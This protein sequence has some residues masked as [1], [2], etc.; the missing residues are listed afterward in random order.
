MKVGGSIAEKD[1]VAVPFGTLAGDFGILPLP[2]KERNHQGLAN[3]VSEA[4]LLKATSGE[5]PAASNMTRKEAKGKR[6]HN[7][8]EDAIKVM[9][10]KTKVKSTEAKEQGDGKEAVLADVLHVDE[11]AFDKADVF[12]FPYME[13]QP[14]KSPKNQL[15]RKWKNNR[16]RGQK[17]QL[18]TK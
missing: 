13:E 18:L 11:F 4:P 16:K 14:E 9:E 10:K 8:V 6:Y 2:A 1:V 7:V 5:V 3:E 17:R 15:L 12:D